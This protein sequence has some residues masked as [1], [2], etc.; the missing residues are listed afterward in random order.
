MNLTPSNKSADTRGV[1]EPAFPDRIIA[2]RV[3]PMLAGAALSL[4]PFTIFSV[5][6]VPIA[7]S[8]DVDE[9][10]VGSLRG[11]GGV[12][13]L[14]AG[15][16]LAPI[17]GRWARSWAPSAALVG[18]AGVCVLATA[19]TVPA[20][21]AFCL[22]IGLCTALLTPLLITQAISCFSS[23]GNSGRAATLI[24][25][26]QS[27]A[28]V[29]A[30]PVTGLL[31]LAGGWR[32]ALWTTAGAALAL[33]AVLLW[34]RLHENVADEALHHADYMES[35]ARLW[36]RP[37]LLN[38]I[39]ISTLRT[40]AFMGQLAFLAVIY[41]RHFSMG[42]EAFALVWTLSG[43]AFFVGNYAA[44]RW[45]R[46]AAEAP[47]AASLV[48]AS[49]ILAGASGLPLI[50][51]PGSLPLALLGT[52]LMSLSHAVIAA[53][54]TTLIAHR[55]QQCTGAAFSLNAAGQSVGV[56]AGAAL[57]GLGLAWGN[58]LGVTLAL[59]LPM[60]IALLLAVVLHRQH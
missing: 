18:L 48:M 22:G 17:V 23:P 8:V 5:L 20:L 35:F 24:T 25:A 51:L 10:A 56:F 31:A 46:R 7:A 44:G 19:G 57:G 1:Q 28:A 42:P 49:G 26:V 47:R 12:A 2:L 53:I 33:A 6:L 4:F 15:V 36:H 39:G 3:W 59:T 27:L 29:A 52:M 14:L 11:L 54:V 45:A 30:G 55:G 50:T 60:A 43:A 21:V 40:T 34:R 32:V 16:L 37:E 41:D 58:M 38:L 9:A 13:A